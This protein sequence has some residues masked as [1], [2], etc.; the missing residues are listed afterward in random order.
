MMIRGVGPVRFRRIVKRAGSALAAWKASDMEKRSWRDFLSEEQVKALIQGP[1]ENRLQ[2]LKEFLEERDLWF[3]TLACDEYPSLLKNIITPPPVLFGKGRLEALKR[4]CIGMVGARKASRYGMALASEFASG[5]AEAGLVVV[6]GLALGIDSAA[7][8]ACL[9]AGGMTIAVKG[10]G[11][12]F[13]YPKRNYKLACEIGLNG[14]VISELMP[15]TPPEPG[16]FPA[17]NRI[18]SG[19]SIGIVV[20]EADK[21]SGSLITARLAAEQ[22]R[23]VMAVPGSVFSSTSRGCHYLI[24]QGALLVETVEDI[25]ENFGS[26]ESDLVSGAA[27]GPV[28]TLSEDMRLVV[29]KLNGEPQHIDDIAARCQMP[30]EKVGAILLELELMDIV[31]AHGGYKFSL[32]KVEV[33]K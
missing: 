14:A 6:S 2:R 28:V 27:K 7:H 22:G 31:M 10:C 16:N 15:G 5:L 29:D 24:K 17:R 32:S 26:G 3:I 4:R 30:V 1:D 33:D 13:V 21:R 18:I 8:K 25:L 23:E 9:E 12:D 19:L 20:V 11:I